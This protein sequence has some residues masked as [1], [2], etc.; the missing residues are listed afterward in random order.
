MDRYIAG[1]ILIFCGRLRIHRNLSKCLVVTINAV[2]FRKMVS[3][4]STNRNKQCFQSVYNITAHL[5]CWCD[6]RWVSQEDID[7]PMV[8]VK[9]KVVDENEVVDLYADED[10]EDMYG[11]GGAKPRGFAADEE[12]FYEDEEDEEKRL[13]KE[14]ASRKVS[15]QFKQISLGS[16]RFCDTSK[17]E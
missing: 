4:L 9:H 17:F 10:E 14:K 3:P 13:A 6:K 16:S 15:V 12:E 7:P 8:T 5:H 11:G 2:P 1:V